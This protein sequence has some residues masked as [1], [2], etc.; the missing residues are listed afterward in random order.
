MSK[1]LTSDSVPR[2]EAMEAQLQATT[3]WSLTVVP[4]LIPVQDFFKLLASEAVL[5]VHLG[6]ASRPA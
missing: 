1:S 6:A 3:G 5:Y 2:I 4:G